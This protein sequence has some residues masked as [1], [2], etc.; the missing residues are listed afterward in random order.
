[1]L[2]TSQTM[3]DWQDYFGHPTGSKLGILNSIYQIGS[4]SS[5][6]FAYVVLVCGVAICRP[7]K[8]NFASDSPFM[9]DHFGRKIPITVGCLVMI[10]GAFLSA[11]T[12]G[13][14]STSPTLNTT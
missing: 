7:T 2:N 11:F 4:I 3:D 9:A 6:P 12:N 10:L 8:T 14:G 13:F 5:F 1:M